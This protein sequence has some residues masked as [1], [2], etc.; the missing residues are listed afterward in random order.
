[1]T[2]LY[3]F[4][5]KEIQGDNHEI[6]GGGEGE[7]ELQDY[8]IEG[9]NEMSD[10]IVGGL[11]VS[12]LL[13]KK[14]ND[15]NDSALYSFFDNLAIPIGLSY[16]PDMHECDPNYQDSKK[17]EINDGVISDSLYDRL[18]HLS[19]T[20]LHRGKARRTRKKIPQ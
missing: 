7:G 19:I 2:E 12:A 6:Q 18:F 8:H 16:F 17:E 10:K 4:S 1:M 14:P 11:S 9:H 3:V 15:L 13:K 20:N 5:S